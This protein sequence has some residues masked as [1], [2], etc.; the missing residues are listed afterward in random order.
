MTGSRISILILLLMPCTLL[1]QEIILKGRVID[2]QGNALPNASVQL[3]ERNQVVAQAKAGPD[4]QFL[5]KVSSTGEF[6]IKAG[7]PGFRSARRP[8]TVR[9]SG[10]PEIAISVSQVASRAGQVHHSDAERR[11]SKTSL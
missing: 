11:G 8:L 5:L 1:A 7:A 10:N 3:I 2:P 6:V 4:G 9:P